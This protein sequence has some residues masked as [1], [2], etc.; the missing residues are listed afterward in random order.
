MGR[1]IEWYL[2]AP[3]PPKPVEE[4]PEVVEPRITVADML[5]ELL[6]NKSET[7]EDCVV[8]FRDKDGTTGV[9]ASLETAADILLLVKQVEHSMIRQTTIHDDSGPKGA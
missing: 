3:K 7:V 4:V 9:V 1:L 6:N 5:R 8:I 2:P